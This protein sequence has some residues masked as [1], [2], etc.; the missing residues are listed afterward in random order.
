[1]TYWTYKAPEAPD[2]ADL[3]EKCFAGTR[4]NWE[5]LSPGFRR[6]IVR[7]FEKRAANGVE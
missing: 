7:S 2:W 5:Q 3:P 4:D 6:E 1:M